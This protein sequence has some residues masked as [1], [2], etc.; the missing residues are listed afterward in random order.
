NV[1][2]IPTATVGTPLTISGSV[3]DAN[4]SSFVISV[5]LPGSPIKTMS[6][7]SS[8]TFSNDFYLSG[9][10]GPVTITF[11]AKDKLGQT[12]TITKTTTYN[13]PFG[14]TNIDTDRSC[15]GIPGN[16]ASISTNTIT[17]NRD[18]ASVRLES[19]K[20]SCF[21]PVNETHTARVVTITSR[22]AVGGSGCPS[23]EI[24]LNVYVTAKNG[25][26]STLSMIA[27]RF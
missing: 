25:E 3:Y 2:S 10:E 6:Y 27:N 23:N 8:G 13:K 24:L 11:T 7:S 12:T 16:C 17:Y 15:V 4:L 19:P 18:I 26:V 1:G 22:I 20:M 14:W 9:N 5:D 21:S